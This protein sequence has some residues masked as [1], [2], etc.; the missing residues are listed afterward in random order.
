M[1]NDDFDADFASVPEY[2]R[3]YRS[4]GIQA[5]PSKEP[6][7]GQNWKRPA[8]ATW[9]EFESALTP[10]DTFDQWYGPRGDHLGRTN[11]GLI[12]GRAS[13]GIFVVDLDTHAHPEAA[14]WWQSMQDMQHRA[15]DLE[16]AQQTTGGGGKQ[17]LFRAP[18]GWSPPTSKTPVGVDIRGEGGFAVLPPSRHAS[19][20]S[21]TWDAGLAP[22]EVGV[23]DAPQWLCNEIDALVNQYGGHRAGG[24]SQT[25]SAVASGPTVRTATPSSSLNAFGLMI[26]GRED[27]ATKLVWARVVDEHRQCPI[28]PGPAEIDL[29]TET[30]FVIY[31]RNVK[32]RLSD[33]AKSNEE[34]LEREGRGKIMLRQKMHA[35]FAQWDGKVALHAEA[36]APERPQGYDAPRPSEPAAEQIR[37]DP[38]TG[39]IFTEPSPPELEVLSLGDIRRLR[40]PAYLVEG[41]VIDNGLGFVFGPPGCGKTF[42]QLSMALSIAYARPEWFGRK[43]EKHGPVIYISSE[44]SSDMKFRI[45][46]WE[47]EHQIKDDAA[48]FYLIRQSLNFMSPADVAKLLKAVAWVATREGVSPVLIVVDTVSRVIPGV[49]ENLQKDVTLFVK[50]CDMLRE[51]FGSTVVGVH[52]T[53]RAGNLRGSTVLDGAGDFLLGVEREE[54]SKVGQIIAKKIKSAPDGWR[55]DFDLKVV[56]AGDIAGNDSLVA[57]SLTS[58]PAR[59]T[60]G[61]SWPDRHTCQQIL[62]AIKAAWA[63]GRP[64]SSYPQSKKDGRYAP[65]LMADWGIKGQLAQTM[66]EKWLTTDVLSVEV[67]DPKTKVKGLKVIGLID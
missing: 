62:D 34:L 56:A 3:F 24:Q 13:G 9:R 22:W 31:E 58:A 43:I 30:L 65:M 26:D 32:S 60:A 19:G 47:T 35:A 42:V 18:T 64:W 36:G 8:L 44:G 38:E 20:Q 52:H 12:T 2:A 61:G 29:M 5:V 27:Y 39:E 1:M 15:G 25:S 50:A 21:Y 54:N 45:G 55:Q 6:R 23:S 59:A 53:S 28:K 63:S 49:D 57:I 11:L 51:A 66:I 37:F 67:V 4:L 14:M 40:N 41:M 33:P 16:T 7:E 48:P 17:L 46:A 10:D